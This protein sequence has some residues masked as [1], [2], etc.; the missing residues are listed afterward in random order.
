MKP[1]EVIAAQGDI[2]L[3]A[4]QE[5]I[6]IMVS[7][8]GDRPVQV[9]SHYH[10]AEVN[11]LLAFDRTEA[12]G[13]RLDLPAGTAM[14]FEPGQMREVRLVPFRGL[15]RVYGFNQKVMGEL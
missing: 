3:N 7:N 15:R 4:G 14:R 10:F 12:D 2:E 1:G 6:A 9:G 8:R 11:P 13:K 5:A